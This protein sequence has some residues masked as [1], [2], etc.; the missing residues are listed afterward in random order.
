VDAEGQLQ[1]RNVE[2]DGTH[3]DFLVR[4]NAYAVLRRELLPPEESGELS[5]PSAA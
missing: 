4:K 5:I 1:V 2:V 3:S